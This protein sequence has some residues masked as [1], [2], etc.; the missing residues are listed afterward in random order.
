M[1]ALETEQLGGVADVVMS[2]FNLL[3]NILALVRI[4]R[5]LQAGELFSGA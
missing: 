1:A 5:L 3:E 4:A 2:L